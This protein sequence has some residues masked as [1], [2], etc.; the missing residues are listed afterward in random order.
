MSEGRGHDVSVLSK[1]FSLSYLRAVVLYARCRYM[2]TLRVLTGDLQPC[3]FRADVL[4]HAETFGSD[5]EQLRSWARGNT[6]GVTYRLQASDI[7]ICTD[8][9]QNT[10]FHSGHPM[11]EQTGE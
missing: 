9:Q 3:D 2:T 1:H 8:F 6:P 10:S 4:A 7:A 5:Q 11:E